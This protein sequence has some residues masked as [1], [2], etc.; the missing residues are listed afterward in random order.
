M[1]NLFIAPHNDDETLFGA[2]TLIRFKPLVLVV[3][4]SWLQY[5]RGENITAEQRRSE[6]Y[7]AMKMAGCPVFFGGIRDDVIDEWQVEHLLSRFDNLDMVYFPA[8]IEGGNEHHNLISRVAKKIC[9]L[10]GWQYKQYMTYSKTQLYLVG[11]EESP[12]FGDAMQL[13]EKMLAC[14]Q[15]QAALP[16][17]A[18]HFEAVKEKS[19]WF[20]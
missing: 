19:E 9:L 13:K 3:T 6:T 7:E 16:A 2:F 1:N 5:N 20:T 15:S 11:T 18:P 10:K 12:P 14:Y 8:E 4:D 17:T